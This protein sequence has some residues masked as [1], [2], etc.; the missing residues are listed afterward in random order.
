VDVQEYE[1][2]LI[3]KTITT[4]KPSLQTNSALTK[5]TIKLQQLPPSYSVATL[6]NALIYFTERTLNETENADALLHS[7]IRSR[8]N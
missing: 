8:V 5:I 1:K 3:S 6:R 7:A 2:I 4:M